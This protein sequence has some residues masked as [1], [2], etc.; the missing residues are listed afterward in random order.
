MPTIGEVTTAEQIGKNWTNGRQKY[1]WLACESCGKER[2]TQVRV[3]K[4]FSR[5][6]RTCGA[7]ENIKS[8]AEKQRGAN[9][10]NW[11]G[12]RVRTKG[13]IL[14]KLSP[15]DFF[16]PM[17]QSNGYVYEHRLVMAQHLRRCLLPMP[18]E[19]V[20]HKDGIHDHNEFTNLEL[21]TQSDH[22]RG[23]TKG[24][25]DGYRQGYQDAHSHS[26]ETSR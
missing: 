6:C 18:F 21:Q 22:M 12:G 23:H 20:N 15:D 8:F 11:K 13:Y 14:I 24:Y 1:V 19:V 17:A 26:Q 25:R 10:P 4:I 2:W 7:R 16:F 3:G 5:F 9:H